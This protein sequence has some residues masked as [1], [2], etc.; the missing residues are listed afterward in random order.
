MKKLIRS[1]YSRIQPDFSEI[2]YDEVELS[3]AEHFFLAVFVGLVITGLAFIFS[4]V[5]VFVEGSAFF[6]FDRAVNTTVVTA[7]VA[8]G[9][10]GAYFLL[11]LGYDTIAYTFVFLIAFFG[12][13][14][15]LYWT[16]SDGLYDPSIM[17]GL[18][19]MVIMSYFLSDH[20][21]QYFAWGSIAAILG[22]FALDYSGYIESS[23]PE[24]Q[25][26]H[27]SVVI[28]A[29]LLVQYFLR[30]IIRNANMHSVQLFQNRDDLRKYQ[31]E[32]ENLVEQRT[33]ELI[34]AR[35]RAESANVSKSQFLANMSHE[36]R[37][38]L[39]AII[40]Y[41]E[42]LG[43]DLSDWNDSETV[44]MQDD[45]TRIHQAARNLLELINSI[46]DLSKVEANE[47]ILH[48]QPVKVAYLID[49]VIS[50]FGPLVSKNHNQLI[51]HE[52]PSDLVAYAD[53]VKLRQVLINLLGNANKFTKNGRIILA[54]IKTHNDV[55]ITVTDTGI[56]ISEEFLPNLFKPFRQEEGDLSRK[57]Q[58]TGLGLAITKSF[59]EMMGGTIHVDTA[60]GKGTTFSIFI[61][62]YYDHIYG[63]QRK[64]II[65]LMPDL[66]TKQLR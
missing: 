15:G 1:I 19:I 26:Y 8:V 6:E 63:G 28:I 41:S 29:F 20:Y 22:L 27:L 14:G 54:A 21:I 35:D 12:F 11:I 58:G 46:L 37:T 9:L 53:K 57:Y 24:V 38:P 17:L 44:E 59:I 61:P 50:L 32:L 66:V 25:P 16:T 51:M 42:M 10:I 60:V 3:K 56:G 33:V 5:G 34:D 55:R 43:E 65:D 4:V 31:E 49:D 18:S 48:L 47:M 52:I 64:D 13:W 62:V 23:H 45:A 2:Y 7:V 30:M 39:N 40:G 36:L